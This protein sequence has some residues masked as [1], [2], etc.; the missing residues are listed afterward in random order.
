M[1]NPVFFR[2]QVKIFSLTWFVKLI[3][4]LQKPRTS[5]GKNINVYYYKVMKS[6]SMEVMTYILLF[7][8]PPFLSLI[9]KNA[10]IL[11]LNKTVKAKYPGFLN[12]QLCPKQKLISCRSR[13]CEFIYYHW[14]LLKQTCLKTNDRNICNEYKKSGCEKICWNRIIPYLLK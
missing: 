12:L 9:S 8:C 14:Q 2:I 1:F 11:L 6:R 4:K 5:N 3:G 7:N 10:N 13:I